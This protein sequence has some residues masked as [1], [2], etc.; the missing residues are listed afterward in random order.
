MGDTGDASRLGRSPGVGNGNPSRSS[1]L[2]NPMDR[3]AWRAVVHGVPKSQ[4]QLSTHT[5]TSILD[6]LSKFYTCDSSIASA[7]RR[8]LCPEHPSHLSTRSS[9]DA[10]LSCCQLSA[11]PKLSWVSLFLPLIDLDKAPRGCPGCV[12]K[13]TRLASRCAVVCPVMSD[14]LWPHGLQLT[15]PCPSPSPGVCPSSCSLHRWC[16]PAISFSG[17]LFFC[18]QSFPAS[19]TFPVSWLFTSDDQNTEASAWAS[20]LPVNIQGWSP[21]RL[22]GLISLLSKGLLGVFCSTAVRRHQFFGILPSLESSSH[23]HMWPPGRP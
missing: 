16:H 15:R 2:G 1:C 13:S 21:L 22:T 23:N 4:T 3:G 8:G 17:A 5:R 19:G 12:A 9:R 20:V 7:C 14:S 6:E 10:H 18:P 11:V